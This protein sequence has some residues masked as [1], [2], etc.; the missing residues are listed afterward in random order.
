MIDDAPDLLFDSFLDVGGDGDVVAVCGIL[1]HSDEGGANAEGHGLFGITHGGRRFALQYGNMEALIN[2][3]LII[4]HLGIAKYYV[5]LN[6][7]VRAQQR[8]SEDV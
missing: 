8:Q 4:L 2:N 7:V 3:K 1:E 5:M 6:T